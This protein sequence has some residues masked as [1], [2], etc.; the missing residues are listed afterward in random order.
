[1]DWQT[2]TALGIV[3]ITLMIFA[4]RM[5]TR[6]KSSSSCGKSCGGCPPKKP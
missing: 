4:Y 6:P 2:F 1:M 5:L 3:A